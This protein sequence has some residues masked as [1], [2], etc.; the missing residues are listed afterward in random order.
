MEIIFI[1]ISIERLVTEHL[2]DLN[3]LH[4]MENTPSPHIFVWMR[5]QTD[6]KIESFE[7]DD[8]K[9]ALSCHNAGASLYFRAPQAMADQVVA[10]L[11]LG[12][13]MHVK[14]TILYIER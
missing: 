13:G 5:N 14:I 7:L 6:G 8:R 1:L 2:F 10:D 12:L 9:A 11:T 3:L 4:L